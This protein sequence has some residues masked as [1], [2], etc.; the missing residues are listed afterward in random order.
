VTVND[1]GGAYDFG[2]QLPLELERVEVTRGVPASQ[3]GGGLSGLFSLTTRSAKG[4]AGTLSS[5]DLE[6]GSFRWRRLLGT[7]SGRSD[8]LDWNVGALG[9]PTDN[10]QP[11][12][13]PDSDRQR[14]LFKTP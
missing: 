3:F 8:R 12:I 2:K 1:P 7:T 10:Q 6:L 14:W 9:V 11:N 13:K 5:G 4:D